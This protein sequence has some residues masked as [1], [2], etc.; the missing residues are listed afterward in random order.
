MR[1]TKGEQMEELFR[2]FLL[3]GVGTLFFTR[4]KIEEMVNELVR[5]G[6]IASKEKGDL[7]AQLLKKGEEGKAEWERKMGEKLE[8]LLAH[9]KVATKED[10]NRLEKK[11]ET[12]ERKIKG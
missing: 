10:I 9:T 1:T 12:L 6:G 11:M 5:C 8:A 7:L 3:L 2:K 4:E